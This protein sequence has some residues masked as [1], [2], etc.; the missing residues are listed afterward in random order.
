MLFAVDFKLQD[1]P[2]LDEIN[3]PNID[4]VRSY[5]W[6]LTEMLYEQIKHGSKPDNMEFISYIR[7]FYR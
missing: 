4:A 3:V 2:L 5:V 7:N 6:I 1:L